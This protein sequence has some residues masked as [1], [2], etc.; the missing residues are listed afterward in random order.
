[1]KTCPNLS[2]SSL[3]IS[4]DF[5]RK[6]FLLEIIFEPQFQQ[7]VKIDELLL[8]QS[9]FLSRSKSASYI[10]RGFWYI[11]H[12]R[13]YISEG[14]RTI[15]NQSEQAATLHVITTRV[16]LPQFAIMWCNIMQQ[17]SH[18][19]DTV[20]I[21]EGKRQTSSQR[22]KPPTLHSTSEI[23]CCTCVKRL[24]RHHSSSFRRPGIVRGVGLLRDPLAVAFCGLARTRPAS[25]AKSIQMTAPQRLGL[26]H[27][28]TVP[29]AS[30]MFGWSRTNGRNYN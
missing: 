26:Q 19:M 6:N 13:G 3:L 15:D 12:P 23:W 22:V 2:L 29:A 25:W 30:D 7:N 20:F 17:L 11:C 10:H 14:E 1:M 5:N 4:F 18:C 9:Q 27:V 16:I 8:S 21:I 24:Y 28:A